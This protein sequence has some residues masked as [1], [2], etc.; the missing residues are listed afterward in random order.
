MPW[1]TLALSK[2]ELLL[3]FLTIVLGLGLA[4]VQLAG[5]RLGP[6]AVLFAGIAISA[7]LAPKGELH[8]AHQ[9]KELGLVLFVY[10]IGVSSGPSFFATFRS[11]GLRLNISAAA[12]LLVAAGCAIGAGYFLK[13]DAGHVAGLFA[14]ALTNTPAL[15]AATEALAGSPAAA[16]AALAYSVAYPFGVLG[17]VLRLRRHALTNAKELAE[18]REKNRALVAGELIT[19]NFEISNDAVVGKSIGELRVRD[20]VGVLI[21]RTGRPGESLVP[22][23]YTPLK[24]GDLV[25]VVGPKDAMERALPFFGTASSR[26]LEASRERVDMRRIL[27][28]RRA[29]VGKTL[30]E[31]ELDKR[32]NAQVTRV[33][34]GDLDMFPSDHTRL[35]IGDRL[36]VV[37]PVERL[38]ELSDF[39]GDSYKEIAHI[40]LIA[41]S[42]GITA[43]L[44][45]AQVPIPMPGGALSL[46]IAGG[47]LLVG[48][49]LGQLGSFGPFVWTIPDEASITMRELG[50]VCFLAAVGVGAGSQLR[51][52][53]LAEGFQ[54]FAAGAVIT[55]ATVTVALLLFS[56]LAKADVITALGAATGTQTQPAAL[57]VAHELSG[58]SEQT[59]VAYAIVYPVAMIGKI[60]IAQLLTRLG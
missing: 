31:L 40:D 4:R 17:A 58:Q 20:E 38:P 25:T 56:K 50:L 11:N 7:W 10:C 8:I 12:A 30:D 36:R 27:V 23:K 34:R 60:L 5:V 59:Y 47:P 19:R 16:H 55:F 43:G 15:G 14:G 1:L 6:S 45:V 54:L 33:R 49:A 51:T 41:L 3:M 9:V 48:L 28:S 21:S 57:A 26:R 44:L 24:K 37:A 29:L 53:A 2:S 46:G 52:V 39:F 32:F 18:Q 35:Q 22:T 42:L 13:L